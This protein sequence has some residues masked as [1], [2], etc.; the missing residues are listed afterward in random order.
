MTE[1]IL[2]SEQNRDLEVIHQN[3][4]NLAIQLGYDEQLTVDS[5]ERGIRFYQGRTVE[6]CLELGKRL[7]LLKELAP[8]GEFVSRIDQLGFQLRSAQRLMSAA[9]KFS[10]SKTTTLSL[11]DAAGNSSKL[12]E[13]V[14]L[15]D[16]DIA[17]LSEG[18]TVAGIN[19]DDVERMS[20]RELR[21]A[22]R[23]ARSESDA[24]EQLLQNKNLKIDELDAQLT[25]RRQPDQAQEE[26]HQAE[27][28]A[29]NL[30][31]Q[32]TNAMI[33][34][35]HKYRTDM[36]AAIEVSATS[37]VSEQFDANVQ[38]TFQRIAD[39]AP[40]LGTNVNFEQQVVP[41]WLMQAQA[42]ATDMSNE[43]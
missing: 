13:L 32:A 41:D 11:L 26:A 8:H 35:V 40:T 39:I 1:V 10:G 34:A 29:I 5:L 36:Q 15:D 30:M 24:K 22:L 18:K 7:L 33:T 20:V 37:Y 21:K 19:L 12:L 2:A 3:A 23:D 16:A 43:G 4:A 9:L 17:E 31:A 6:A 28:E 38:F 27:L 42:A 25:R 14:T